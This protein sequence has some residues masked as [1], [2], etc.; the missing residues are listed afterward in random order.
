V[1]AQRCYERLGFRATGTYYLAK[2]AP[3]RSA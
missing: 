3:P 2:F 1:G